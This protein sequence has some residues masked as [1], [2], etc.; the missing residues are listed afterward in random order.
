MTPNVR[1]AWLSL[2]VY[3]PIVTPTPRASSTC[4][5]SA[6]AAST[7]I[8]A[9]TVSR[10]TPPSTTEVVAEQQDPAEPGQRGAAAAGDGIGDREVAVVVRGGEER[11]VGDVRHR[12]QCGEAPRRRREVVGGDDHRDADD[13]GDEELTPQRDE[14]IGAALGAQVPAGVQQGRGEGQDRGDEHRAPVPVSVADDGEHVALTDGVAGGHLDL[15]HGAGALGRDRFSI[16]IA[17]S[18]TT[19]S[20][21]PMAWPGST[22]TLTIVPCIGAVTSPLPPPTPAPALVA[23]RLRLRAGAAATTTVGGGSVGTHTLTSKRLPL[24]STVPARGSLPTSSSG[25]RDG[26]GRCRRR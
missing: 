4:T 18:T 1:E 26:G 25:G 20:P 14:A 3:T 12:G 16:F 23:A 21:A 19:A 2:T 22:S 8:P 5:R 9:A 24:T 13:T 17:S 7:T 10:P 6:P 15:A 11:G